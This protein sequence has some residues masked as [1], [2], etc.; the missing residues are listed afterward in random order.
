MPP[1]QPV[2]TQYDAD[3]RLTLDLNAYLKEEG[4]PNSPRELRLLSLL[5]FNTGV[6]GSFGDIRAFANDVLEQVHVLWPS[7]SAHPSHGNPANLDSSTKCFIQVFCVLDRFPGVLSHH[8]FKRNS[9][10][11]SE[12]NFTT[13]SSRIPVTDRWH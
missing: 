7:D 8:N 12:T 4:L 1:S 10:Y 9:R 11:I 13:T 5:P 2:L 6:Y 3:D